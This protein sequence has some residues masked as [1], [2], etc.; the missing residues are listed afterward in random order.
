MYEL[1]QISKINDFIFCPYSI[2]LHSI[3]EEFKTG[4][5]QQPVQIVGRLRHEN[6]D[7]KAYSTSKQ[8]LQGLPIYSEK[9]KLIGKADI[10]DQAEKALIERKNKVKEIYDGYKYQLYAQYL[11]L[12]E[13]GYP[14]E[15]LFIHSL[16][17][18]QRYPIPLPDEIETKKFEDLLNKIWHFD[19]HKNP[20]SISSK[21]CQ[22]CIY[23]LLCEFAQC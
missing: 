11:C 15:K 21:K 18:N 8:I 22:N 19:P 14:V 17:D 12:T 16:S 4:E 5:Y 6:I 1:I 23:S 10:Y 3:Y 7:S 20:V 2:Y 13:Q 9:Y